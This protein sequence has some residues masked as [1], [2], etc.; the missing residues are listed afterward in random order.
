MKKFSN[1]KTKC[2][3]IKGTAEEIY[4]DL[5]DLRDLIKTDLEDIEKSLK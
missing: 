5:D 4:E 1:I 2:T 3:S